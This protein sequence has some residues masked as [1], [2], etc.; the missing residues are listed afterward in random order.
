MTDRKSPDIQALFSA[1]NL[2]SIDAGIDSMVKH[3]ATSNW[4]QQAL[5]DAVRRDPLDALKDAEVLVELLELRF[6]AVM[7]THGHI[8]FEDPD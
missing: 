6:N 8:R 5:M 7:L 3:P 1:S 2:P 4:L